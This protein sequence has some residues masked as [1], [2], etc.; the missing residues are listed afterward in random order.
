[1]DVTEARKMREQGHTYDQLS[2]HFG[3]SASQIRRRL[4][5]EQTRRRR[6]RN[7]T[8]QLD[9]VPKL[10]TCRCDQPM[11]MK[12]IDEETKRIDIRCHKCA[13]F[14]AL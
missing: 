1:V 7:K 10:R 2:A 12:E 5:P 11:P 13:R 4:N 6:R 14:M 9:P 8:H 3:M